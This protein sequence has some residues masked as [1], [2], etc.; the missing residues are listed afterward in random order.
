MK[1]ID[2]KNQI[3][4]RFCSNIATTLTKSR[5]KI[6]IVNA[7]YVIISGN[8]NDIFEKYDER[9]ERKSKGNPQRNPKYPRYPDAIVKK[10]IRRI[11][12]KG[13]KGDE[14]IKRLKVYIDVPEEYKKEIS[15]SPNF[16]KEIKGIT[17]EE[18]SKHLG[19][20]LK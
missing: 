19:A 11:L 16:S 2:A 15:E 17:L 6:I 12:P 5:D 4:G 1:V 3:L 10:T 7:R 9:A 8:K 20:N 14:A 18:L 13:P